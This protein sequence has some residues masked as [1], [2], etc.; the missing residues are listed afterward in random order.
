M[1]VTRSVD[2]DFQASVALSHAVW[3]GCLL[4]EP[5][6]TE[7]SEHRLEHSLGFT[8]ASTAVLIV[9]MLNDFLDPDG[10]M[11][12]LEGRALF[13]PINR[14]IDAARFAGSPIIW[15]CDEHPPGDR[16]FE[17]RTEHCLRGTWGAEIVSALVPGPDEY[18]VAK[19]RYSGFFETDL[20]LRLRELGIDHLIIAGVVT[21]I[22]V[23]STT[24][25]AFFRGYDVMIPEECVAATSDREQASSLY[26]IDTHYGTVASLRSILE[27]YEKQGAS[28]G[29]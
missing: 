4:E 13:D 18:R 20:D 28:V 23:R 26:D 15:V 8:A 12:L 5:T 11:P 3:R 19:R 29:T 21:N 22:C 14:L 1:A 24:H 7:F 27:L 10:A 25:D 16:E 6:V 9:D 2:T 17:K